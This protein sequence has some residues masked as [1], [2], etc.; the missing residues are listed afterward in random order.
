MSADAEP[1]V[2]ALLTD[3]STIEI[4]AARPGDFDLV[5]KMHEKLTPDSLYLRYFSMSPERGR[6]GSAPAL[7]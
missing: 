6:T 7:P 5:R 3:G 2:Y 1:N 4:R